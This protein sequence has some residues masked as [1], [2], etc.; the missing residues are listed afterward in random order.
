MSRWIQYADYFLFSPSLTLYIYSICSHLMALQTICTPT[1][2]QHWCKHMIGSH[3]AFK[4]KAT[5]F[6]SQQTPSLVSDGLSSFMND[7]SMLSPCLEDQTVISHQ[8]FFSLYIYMLK[9]SSRMHG[10][11]YIYIIIL[12]HWLLTDNLPESSPCFSC[13]LFH[14]WTQSR[15]HT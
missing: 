6:W 12:C 10:V 7:L 2:P 8:L 3:P 14:V 4:E 5:I 1:C 11:L 13:F 15:G 9:N